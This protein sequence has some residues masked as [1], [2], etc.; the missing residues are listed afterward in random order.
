[1]RLLGVALL[2]CLPLVGAETG[3]L[4]G[5]VRD[6][7]DGVMP[8]TSITCIQQEMGFRFAR[9][10]DLLGNYTMTLPEGHYKI[11]ASQPGFRGVAEIGVFVAGRHAQRVDFRMAPDGVSDEAT[12]TDLRADVPAVFA[13]EDGAVVLRPDSLTGFPLND[14][15]VTGI[16]AL[17][18]GML[19]TPASGG[20]PGQISSLGARPNTNRYM[21]DGVS[22][23]NA[24]SGGGWPSI[25]PG[26][27]LPAMT[28]L[29]TT[30]PL[31][32]PDA[33]DEVR[34][35]P[36]GFIPEAGR[37]PG[38][39][40]SIGTKA[41]TSQFHGSLFY[42]GRPPTWGANDWFANRY[43][44]RPSAP[45][46][47][48]RGGSAGGPLRRNRTFFFLSAERLDL[49]QIYSWTTTVPSQAWRALAPPNVQSLLDMFPMPNGPALNSFGIGELIGSS[50][51]PNSLWGVNGRLDHALTNQ[52][53]AF[54]RT[55][56]T[57]SWSDSGLTQIDY[58][59]YRSSSAVLGVTHDWAWGMED[60]RVSFSRTVAA[61]QWLP[62]TTPQD[63]GSFYSQ[64]P[65]FAAEFSTISVGGAGSV[66]AGESGRTSQD[67]IQISEVLSR[68][69]GNH[70]LRVG[71]DYLQLRPIRGGP[72]S[73][74]DVAFSS[75]TN[76][77]TDP[78][79]VWVTYSAIQT[80]ATRLHQFSG[81]AQDT[82]K[83]HPALT[84]TGGVRALAMIP[85][86]AAP[87]SSL[88]S[89][90]ELPGGILYNAVPAGTPLWRGNL[91]KLD[92][93]ISVAWRVTPRG[94]TVLRASW[95]SFHDG[96]FAV[97]T[98][99]L[100]GAP[101]SSLR[102]EVSSQLVSQNAPLFPVQ[103]GYGFSS[104]LHIPVYRRWGVTLQQAWSH[105]DSIALSYSGMSGN[106]LLRRDTYF[107]SPDRVQ[108]TGVG[109]LS[110][111][112]NDGASN[113]NSFYATYRRTLASGLQAS[114]SY[115]WSHS[116]D[117]GSSDSLLFLVLPGNRAMSDRGDSDFD[118]RHTLSLNFSYT[119]P[120]PGFLRKF[121][122]QWTLGTY[123]Y[124][125]TGFPIDVLLSETL[126]GSAVSNDRPDLVPGIPLWI[127]DAS[128][129]GGH[130]LNPN[131]FVS[132]S[133]LSGDLGRNTV[134][135]FGS[136][137]SDVAAERLFRLTDGLRLSFRAEAYNVFN[138]AQF[139]DPVRFLSNPLFGISQ[140][141]LNM[142]LGT[143]SPISGQTPA[144]QMGG[145][146][147]M[148]VS[149]RLS[150]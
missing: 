128:V 142:M 13:E 54:L 50:V 116:I 87:G 10:T 29:G 23:N 78:A 114:A 77:V 31:A 95:A 91:L 134:R 118:A 83:I 21:V 32:L 147:S 92:P 47:A 146:R 93:S 64:Y 124:A 132:P 63:G 40:I 8:G 33:I 150:F 59:S 96:D 75:P 76:L 144:F 72:P 65:S 148:Q 80:S 43:D 34:V 149:L 133:G 39:N 74:W 127:N 85:P 46:L 109:Q 113:Y 99:Q 25:L 98:D 112:T 5:T 110:Y 3:R 88:Y 27:R 106:G 24:V 89:V 123:T 11:V 56:L 139:A 67:Q 145:P 26:S 45:K 126:D 41:G 108:A 125:R 61:S 100:N 131:A 7:S 69:A 101:Y 4:E 19:I 1:M 122:G 36:E 52:T 130:R 38:G 16:M 48:D 119:T 105:S 129:P 137:Q 111:A 60:T 28:A 143:G 58:S 135:G 12:V 44:L 107:N 70:E 140:A 49:R 84:V 81:F 117:V 35:V 102:S 9:T 51:R 2:I 55:S 97:A 57:P 71:A 15:T 53:R 22:A 66:Q 62:P 138:H 18:P 136:W 115:S 37:A 82:W 141:P 104:D 20:E 86:M 68:H 42:A 103:L 6:T 30:H 79:P 94:S 120:A 90:Q 73:N 121:P 17:A 14:R